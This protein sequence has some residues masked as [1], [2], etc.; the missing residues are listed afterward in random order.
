M[1]LWTS[2]STSARNAVELAERTVCGENKPRYHT[3]GRPYEP[4]RPPLPR[5]TITWRRRARATKRWRPC[6]HGPRHPVVP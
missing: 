6:H 1:A 4:R 2:A 3:I 5:T